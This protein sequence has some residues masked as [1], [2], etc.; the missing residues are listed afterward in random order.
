MSMIAA[1]LTQNSPLVSAVHH[2]LVTYWIWLQGAVLFAAVLIFISSI[3]DAILDAMYWLLTLFGH[4][5]RPSTEAVSKK[6][7]KSIAIL[8]PAYAA[9]PIERIG[10]RG[11]VIAQ[12][13][14]LT[15]REKRR[16]EAKLRRG[17]IEKISY[18]FAS[19]SDVAFAIQNDPAIAQAQE[20]IKRGGLD[21]DQQERLWRGIRSTYVRLGDLL[22]RRGVIDHNTLW[23]ALP[24]AWRKHISLAEALRTFRKVPQDKLEEALTAHRAW[25][26][27]LVAAEQQ[28]GVDLPA[29]AAALAKP[30][31]KMREHLYKVV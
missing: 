2:F 12:G 1:M 8:I 7:E 10:G 15:T 24:M 4:R 19:L 11:A 29:R 25:R 22:V 26:P 5:R 31:A 3:D 16:L 18:K 6:P 27:D 28:I 20:I 23:R 21:Q 17:G 30:P 13:E 9:V 14:P